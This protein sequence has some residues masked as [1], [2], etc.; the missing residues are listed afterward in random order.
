MAVYLSFAHITIALF[1]CSTSSTPQDQLARWLEELSQYDMVIQHRPER[2]HVNADAL[3]RPPPPSRCRGV[4]F[5]VNLSDLPCGGCLKCTRAHQ[6]WIAFADE[7]DDVV[8][9]A[10]PGS[11]TYSPLLGEESSLT[12][13]QS[14]IIVDREEAR[15]SISEAA[16]GYVSK[17]LMGRIREDNCEG[18]SSPN[19][20]CQSQ[21]QINHY[22]QFRLYHRNFLGRLGWT[23]FL[24]GPHPR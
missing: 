7:V 9:L 23:A 15:P 11:W 17:K 10:R 18:Q 16:L 21:I 1:S 14:P 24:G 12:K 2:H 8:P 4:D 20:P 13:D 5:T 22:P 3:Y 6:F 19:G